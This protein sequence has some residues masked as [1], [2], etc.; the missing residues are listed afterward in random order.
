M[1]RTVFLVSMT[2]FFLAGA[3]Y[4]GAQT[5]NAGSGDGQF[6]SVSTTSVPVVDGGIWIFSTAVKDNGEVWRSA[7]RFDHSQE[8]TWELS[9]QLPTAP[10]PIN[11]EGAS[12]GKVKAGF[13]N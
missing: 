1:L 4:L 13:R 11:V 6:G 12:W 10:P 2:L 3:F 5:A 7:T 8:F 9:A